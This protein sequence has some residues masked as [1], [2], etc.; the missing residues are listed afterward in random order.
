MNYITKYELE[1]K[2]LASKFS[3]NNGE[4]VFDEN[5]QYKDVFQVGDIVTYKNDA[6]KIGVVSFIEED[7]LNI[8]WNDNSES[9]ENTSDLIIVPPT[10]GIQ[11]FKNDDLL[12]L[13]ENLSNGKND[14]FDLKCLYINDK[15]INEVTFIRA[16]KNTDTLV[17]KQFRRIF[18]LYRKFG[19]TQ[20]FR[21]NLY[22][23]CNGNV[24]LD[25]SRFVYYLLQDNVVY[26]L[27]IDLSKEDLATYLF[28]K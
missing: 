4:L 9:E 20:I 17:D 1:N 13:W 24:E 15:M 2:E 23:I 7:E 14:S 26:Y 10:F 16:Y 19:S 18:S 27:G 6:K 3:I 5:S 28:K 11:L 21:T 8:N 22:T 25:T 12:Q